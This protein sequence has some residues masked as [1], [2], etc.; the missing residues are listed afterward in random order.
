MKKLFTSL[1]FSVSLLISGNVF[2]VPILNSF[3]SATATIFLDFDGHLVQ[4]AVWNGGNPLNCAPSGLTEQ[5]ITDAFYRV[6]EDFRPFNVN[7]T[8][9]STKFLAAPLNRRVRI[10]VTSTSA[11]MPGVGGIAYMGSFTW[12][13]DTPAFVFSDKL[14]PYNTKM[15]AEC[16]S[17]ET[18]HTVGLAHQSKYGN[19][20][21]TPTEPYNLGY[22]TGETGWSP[23][24]GNS[25]YR[26]MT[27]WNNGPTPYGCTELENNL[28]TI[29]TQ[30]GFGYRADDFSETLNS[31]TYA[32]TGNNFS[33]NGIITTNT[34]KDAFKFTL[35]Q[36]LNF[37][38]TASPYSIGANSAGAN[39]DVK[40][41]LYKS[42]P[43]T[44]IATYD[45]LTTMSVT[46]DTILNAGTYYI[47]VSGA[48]NS[49]VSAYGSLGSYT[50][51]GTTSILPIRNVSLNGKVDNNKHNLSWKIIADEP[52]RSVEVQSSLSGSNFSALTSLAGSVTNFT[53]QPFKNNTVYYR[54]KVTSVV[55]QVVYSNVIALKG[56]ETSGKQ[57]SVSTLV[58]SE[59]VVNAAENYKYQLIDLNGRMINN[60]AGLKG[61]NRIN[62]SNQSAG[63][64]ILKL[65]NNEQQQTE[66]ILKQ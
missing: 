10:I 33:V 25:Y 40:I 55:D 60:G 54:L 53:Y 18:G 8:T 7:I 62:V 26:N 41:E 6:A 43:T 13:D 22:G 65:F 21:N 57:F 27:N 46:I 45:P 49:N 31:G 64:Y 61:I 24:M 51:S 63:M 44:L 11:W 23:I 15:V 9:D 28:T 47:K 56:T 12:G 39:L 2:S 1:I 14:G 35:A 3:P 48:G 30:N 17:H 52:I 38:L 58:Q 32:L 37:H 34:D 66:R 16:I 20:C 29:T 4:S 50:I 19:D 42:S 36:N 5:Q 59:I